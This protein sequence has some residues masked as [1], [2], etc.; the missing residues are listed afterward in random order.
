M[1]KSPEIK[2]M[3]T[4]ITFSSDPNYTNLVRAMREGRLGDGSRGPTENYYFDN[5]VRA[6]AAIWHAL[7]PEDRRYILGD[8]DDVMVRVSGSQFSLKLRYIS[9]I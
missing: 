8:D 3:A 2:M 6:L 4:H 7:P 9:Q 5:H 1:G